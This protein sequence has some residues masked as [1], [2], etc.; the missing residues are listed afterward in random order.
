MHIL[1]IKGMKKKKEMIIL[2]NITSVTRFHYHYE[3]ITNTIFNEEPLIEWMNRT[4]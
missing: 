2:P 3:N 1:D 4:Y